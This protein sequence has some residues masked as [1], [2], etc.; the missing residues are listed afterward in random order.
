MAGGAWDA[1]GRGIS[2]G[3]D[4]YF[5]GKERQED[6]KRRIAAEAMDRERL[7]LE[8]FRIQQGMDQY[9]QEQALEEQLHAEERHGA[10]DL[11]SDPNRDI[12]I[13][14][15]IEKDGSYFPLSEEEKDRMKTEGVAAWEAKQAGLATTEF[16][17]EK[18]LA[19]Y[20]AEVEFQNSYAPAYAAEANKPEPSFFLPNGE[21]NH[22][23]A[24]AFLQ[25]WKARNMGDP[26]SN[27]QFLERFLRDVELMTGVPGAREKAQLWLMQQP[28][29]TDQSRTQSPEP[30][31]NM[32]EQRARSMYPDE[33][34]AIIQQRVEDEIRQYLRAQSSV[35]Q[36]VAAAAQQAHEAARTSGRGRAGLFT[37]PPSAG[38]PV[39]PSPGSSMSAPPTQAP[40]MAP[41]AQAPV[42]TKTYDE[43]AA[44]KIAASPY[45]QGQPMALRMLYQ[46]YL[47]TLRQQ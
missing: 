9:A 33:P 38:P 47:S 36:P 12:Y 17:R 21:V 30:V 2:G 15:F 7:G 23:V 34:E 29:N 46:Q 42:A 24:W 27:P 16:E 45:L 11:R 3:V 6:E 13:P 5:R 4:A 25:E 22:S 20:R 32:V 8:K 39:S 14:M 41:Q 37:P 1:L 40:P 19:K 10:L 35:F 26:G 44:E 18:E 43:F 31:R 28:I